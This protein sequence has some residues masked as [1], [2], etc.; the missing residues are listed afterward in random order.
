VRQLFR[1]DLVAELAEDLAIDAGGDD[2]GIDQ[3]PVAIEN[4]EHGGAV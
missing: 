2:F 1:R 3:D 4:G